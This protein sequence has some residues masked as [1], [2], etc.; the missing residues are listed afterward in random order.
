MKVGGFLMQ[1]DM[2]IVPWSYDKENNLFIVIRQ[3]KRVLVKGKCHFDTEEF[4]TRYIWPSMST[5]QLS[6]FVKLIRD[7]GFTVVDSDKAYEK[8]Y[9]TWLKSFAR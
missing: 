3:G 6:K 8:V 1:K 2:T 4:E 5:E 9:K 7:F